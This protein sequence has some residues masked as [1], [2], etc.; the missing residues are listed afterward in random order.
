LVERPPA[1]PAQPIIEARGLT[2]RY[3]AFTAVNDVDLVVETAEVFG[4]LGPNG[5]GKTTTLEMIEGLRPPD[6]GTIRVAGLDA[7]RNSAAVRRIIGVQLQTTALF[8]Y[9]SAVELV[10]LFG[11]LYGADASSAH[12]MGLLA[13]VGL[14]DKH[15]AKVN[16]LSGGQQQRLSIALA[17][18]NQPRVV[19]LDE[20]TTGLDPQARRMMWMTVRDINAAGTTVVLTTHYMEEAEV[21]CDRIAIMDQGR[22]IA[23]DTPSAL[24][25]GLAMEATIRAR[26]TGG[27]LTAADLQRL[28][29]VSHATLEDGVIGVQT[30]DA[31]TS[32]IALLD[33]ARARD[34]TLAELSTSQ[35]SLEDVF[36][37]LTG[38]RYDGDASGADEA[39]D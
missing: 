1:E 39:A 6:H 21:L 38:R 32:L 23:L 5:A 3:G 36:L 11:H 16:Q 19:F 35:A 27:S 12:V 22:V 7:V 37:Q 9:L 30:A 17:L 8:D 15:D 25:R 20:P 13:T 24:I 4:I 10:T 29:A 2:K 31:Q 26:V 14:Q 28:P 18:V 34:L 33:V